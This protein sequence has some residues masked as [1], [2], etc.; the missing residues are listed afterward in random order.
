M[1][2]LKTKDKLNKMYLLF[3]RFS[4]RLHKMVRRLVP[5]CDVRFLQSQCG[6]GKGAAMVTAVAYRLAVQHAERQRVL[7]TLRLSREQLLDVKRRMSEDMERGLSKQ[8]HEQSSL[9]MLPSY[10]RDTPDGT[11]SSRVEDGN[12]CGEKV[13]NAPKFIS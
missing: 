4:R 8:N 1:S 12:K 2:G 11:G 9:K 7:D 3:L 13:G 6:S 10:V 5:D